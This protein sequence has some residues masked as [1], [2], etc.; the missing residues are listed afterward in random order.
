MRPIREWARIKGIPEGTIGSW[1]K[2]LPDGSGMRVGTSWA[3][4]EAEFD[5]MCTA[6]RSHK[7]GRAKKPA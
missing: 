2:Y 3:I 6:A 5:S 1:T 4:T 7:R